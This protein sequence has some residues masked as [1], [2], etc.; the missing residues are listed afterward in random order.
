[1]P[2]RLQGKVAFITGAGSGIGRACA[3]LFAR[4]GARV[5]LAEL[6]PDP[7]KPSWL[8]A[9]RVKRAEWDGFLARQV[10]SPSVYDP[11]WQRPVC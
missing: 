1:V 9:G 7:G 5:V 6:V 8:E 10:A 4:E 3:R 11:V 2:D